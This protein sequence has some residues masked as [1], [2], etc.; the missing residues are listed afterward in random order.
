MYVL[1]KKAMFAQMTIA[2]VPHFGYSDEV[3]NYIYL[4]LLNACQ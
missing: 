4:I 2:S 3:Q 1:I